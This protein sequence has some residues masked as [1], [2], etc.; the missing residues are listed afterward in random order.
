MVFESPA[1]RGTGSI[2]YRELQALVDE[3][4]RLLEGRRVLEFRA[5]PGGSGASAGATDLFLLL[6]ED[7]DQMSPRIVRL[8]ISLAPDLNFM[9]VSPRPQR[10]LKKGLDVPFARR[11]E[12]ALE[13]ARLLRID[14]AARDRVIHAELMTAEGA[15]FTLVAELFGRHANLVLIDASSIVQ[16]AFKQTAGSSRPVIVSQPYPA[17]PEG[18][19]ARGRALKPRFEPIQKPTLPGL[20]LN[21]GADLY[22][23][24]LLE[25]RLRDQL[26][27]EL[28]RQL[29]RRRK[30]LGAKIV[31]TRKK[32]AAA[33]DAD[34]YR[35]WGDLLK[36]HFHLLETGMISIEVPDLFA[37][38][39]ENTVEIPLDPTASPAANLEACYKKYAKLL[40]SLAPLQSLL[41]E[42]ISR[43]EQLDELAEGLEAAESLSQVEELYTRILPARTGGAAGRGFAKD[44]PRR[45]RASRG[46]ASAMGIKR[47]ACASGHIILVG[48]D[49]ATNHR[50]L[51]ITRGKSIW[52]HCHD[53]PG[54]HVVIPLEKG[55]TASLEDLLAAGLLAVHFSKKRGAEQADVIYTERHHVRA[56][57]G[58]PKGRVTVERFKTLHVRADPEQLRRLLDTLAM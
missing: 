17:P 12:A 45:A 6:L 46:S 57:R 2:N 19:P 28:R 27:I 24:R 22:F 49:G 11:L 7:P 42:A 33:E 26:R 9:L 4:R 29:T 53:V 54:A 41:D 8:L 31:D 43:Q 56:L 13:G 23:S 30:R 44:H 20:A 36:T 55:K 15:R 18:S 50:L 38:Q 48:R 16:A 47:F 25:N 32:I 39:P 3:S 51:Q 21:E 14:L 37:D 10:K 40:R 1:S 35:Q 52:M 5:L 58:G 34:R